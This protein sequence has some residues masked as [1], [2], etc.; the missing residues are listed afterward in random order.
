M[1]EFLTETGEAAKFYASAGMGSAL[2]IKEGGRGTCSYRPSVRSRAQS[3]GEM[4][5]L[6]SAHKI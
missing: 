3:S 4:E 5:Q 2:Q 1:T 6:I